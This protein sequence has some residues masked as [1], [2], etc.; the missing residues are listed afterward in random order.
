MDLIHINQQ[1]D[2]SND[3]IPIGIDLRDYYRSV[4]WDIMSVPAKRNVKTYPCCPEPY[5]DIPFNITYTSLLY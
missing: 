5:P 2:L 3:Y 1:E 4:E